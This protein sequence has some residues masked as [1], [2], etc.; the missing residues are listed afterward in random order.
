MLKKKYNKFDREHYFEF[1]INDQKLGSFCYSVNRHQDVYIY[2]LHI[3]NDSN[4]GKGYG[5]QMVKELVTFFKKHY[6]NL[7]ITLETYLSNFPAMSVYLKN[8]FIPYYIRDEDAYMV[9]N[10][11]TLS[12]LE[13]IEE[14]KKRM[15]DQ[16]IKDRYLYKLLSTS[17]DLHYI[18]DKLKLNLDKKL[19]EH[20]D[21]ERA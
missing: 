17:K 3:D 2:N 16:S 4:K 1:S 18:F 7:P 6:P 13:L 15:K 19:W 12:T 21:N 20:W 11:S 9:Y 10:D 14:E 8:N 5:T